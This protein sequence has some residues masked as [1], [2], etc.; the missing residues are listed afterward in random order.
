MVL[1]TH[2]AMMIKSAGKKGALIKEK[3]IG[4][5]RKVL[6]ELE[7]KDSEPDIYRT[8]KE[9]ARELICKT[10]TR[11]IAEEH[12]LVKKEDAGVSAF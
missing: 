12:E 6:G 11:F 7:T 3:G 9:V 10:L 4:Q 8:A 5:A 2:I 1:N